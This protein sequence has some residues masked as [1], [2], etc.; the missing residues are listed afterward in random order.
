MIYEDAWLV[1]YNELLEY[2][3]M[4]GDFSVPKMYNGER[5][6][7]SW[8]C[9]QRLF[10]KNKTLSESRIAKLNEVG[11]TWSQE[12]DWMKRCSQ[13]VE[14]KREFGDCCDNFKHKLNPQLG[15]WVKNQ[16]QCFKN[17]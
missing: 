8:V 15:T 3:S 1:R 10:F 12:D 11:F 13:L 16:H 9:R 7:A 5:S 14:Y 17:K 2:M 6:L 4:F